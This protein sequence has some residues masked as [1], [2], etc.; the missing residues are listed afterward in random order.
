MLAW[1]ANRL[2]GRDWRTMMIARRGLECMLLV[3]TD[4]FPKLLT[5]SSVLRTARVRSFER[6]GDHFFLSRL[7]AKYPSVQGRTGG[8]R[9]LPRMSSD[10]ARHGMDTEV[11]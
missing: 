5:G 10:L 8:F 2:R 6:L 9:I 11:A 7:V 4:C 1:L 3:A